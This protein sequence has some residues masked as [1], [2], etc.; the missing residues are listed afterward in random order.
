MAC[1]HQPN[2]QMWFGQYF[3]ELVVE[4][5]HWCT[6]KHIYTYACH[7]C[8]YIHVQGHYC[9][10]SCLKSLRIIP[11]SCQHFTL[12]FYK[13]W[14]WE[15]SPGPRTLDPMLKIQFHVM[16][17]ELSTIVLLPFTSQLSHRGS[18]IHPPAPLGMLQTSF[19]QATSLIFVS[20]FLP[21]WFTLSSWV[22]LTFS[23]TI[24]LSNYH[25]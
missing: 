22:D 2:W 5:S 13:I 23:I 19:N 11:P 15:K 17:R 10:I 18:C 3:S 14:S 21:Q 24:W 16:N 6:Y 1:C 20:I 12:I 7:A 9:A 25:Y 4:G 8:T